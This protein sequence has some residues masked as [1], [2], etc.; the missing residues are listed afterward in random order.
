MDNEETKDNKL[1]FIVRLPNFVQDQSTDSGFQEGPLFSQDHW[2][3]TLKEIRK[4]I[5]TNTSATISSPF[6]HLSRYHQKM[7]LAPFPPSY[8][9]LFEDLDTKA[10]NSSFNAEAFA[11]KDIF[12]YRQLRSEHLIVR[13]A[14]ALYAEQLTYTF[15]RLSRGVFMVQKYQYSEPLNYTSTSFDDALDKMPSDNNIDTFTFD[16]LFNDMMK[17]TMDSNEI[18]TPTTPTT[19]AA[20]FVPFTYTLGVRYTNPYNNACD[21]VVRGKIPLWC[22]TLLLIEC[23]RYLPI[24]PGTKVKGVLPFLKDTEFCFE[25]LYYDKTLY[26]EMTVIFERFAMELSDP[27]MIWQN[28]DNRGNSWQNIHDRILESIVVCDIQDEEAARITAAASQWAM[29]QGILLQ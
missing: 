5:Y 12:I 20:D 11:A 21:L 1:P 8:Y 16:N 17:Q 15:S 9:E 28:N 7:K 19:P 13:L 24:L 4:G 25:H 23:M 27:Q 14:H 18:T 26:P 3:Y 22:Q 10:A 2:F 6:V 29:S